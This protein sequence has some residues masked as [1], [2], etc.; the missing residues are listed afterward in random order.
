MLNFL[1]TRQY[2]FVY[3]CQCKHASKIFTLCSLRLARYKTWSESSPECIPCNRPAICG[4][5]AS[6][7]DGDRSSV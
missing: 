2:E 5:R 4:C 3:T 6:R 7:Y 1:P